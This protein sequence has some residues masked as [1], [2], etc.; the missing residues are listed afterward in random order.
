MEEVERAAS[1]LHA[2]LGYSMLALLHGQ[3]VCGLVRPFALFARLGWLTMV[4]Q[5]EGGTDDDAAL[6][7]FTLHRTHHTHHTPPRYTLHSPH[8]Q[9]N[10]AQTSP[11]EDNTPNPFTLSGVYLG[12]LIHAIHPFVPVQL[13]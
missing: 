13:N 5:M 7:T 4:F 1:K 11:K 12:T 10:P 2:R 3:G 6:Y 8:N 9:P